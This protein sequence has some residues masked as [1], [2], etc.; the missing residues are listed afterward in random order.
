MATANDE[1]NNIR[2]ETGNGT[3]QTETESTCF[4]CGV[5]CIKYQGIVTITEARQIADIFKISLETFHDRYVDEAWP[6]PENFLLAIYQGACVFLNQRQDSKVTSCQIHTIRPQVCQEWLPGWH[7][8]ECREGL[9]RC[10]GLTV[11]PSGKLQGSRQKI[12]DFNA[13]LESLGR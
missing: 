11:S 6:D 10:W 5:C 7:R 4:R 13:F 9:S 1:N 12:R 8:S 2:L 3:H